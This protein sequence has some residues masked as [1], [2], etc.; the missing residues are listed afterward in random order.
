M[1]DYVLGAPLQTTASGEIIPTEL[2]T[3]QWVNDADMGTPGSDAERT[4]Y[5]AGHT[6]PNQSAAFNALYDRA[7]STSHVLAGDE[8][9]VTTEA[10]VATGLE[11]LRYVVTGVEAYPK[12]VVAADAESEVWRI[13]PGRLVIL[14]CFQNPSGV[15]S[16]DN[17]V[18]YA[19]YTR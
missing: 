3:A 2:E 10:T 14:T 9:L 16:V 12:G 1:A 18:V 15:R 8:F 5:M 6:S 19:H 7:T 13:V 17:F 4:I 11:P